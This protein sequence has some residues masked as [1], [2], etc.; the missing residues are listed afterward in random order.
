M[1]YRSVAQRLIESGFLLTSDL[2]PLMK[3]AE[4]LWDWIV[5]KRST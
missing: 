3:R 1:E 2:D 4:Q 5:E